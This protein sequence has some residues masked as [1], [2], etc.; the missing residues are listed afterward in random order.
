MAASGGG[1]ERFTVFNDGRLSISGTATGMVQLNVQAPASQSVDI[2]R[3]QSSV[4]ATLLAVQN[5]GKLVANVGAVVAQPG[6][7]SG[8]VLQVGGTNAG[9]TGNLQSWVNPSNTIVASINETG[10]L[11]AAGLST[12]GTVSGG[13]V[14]ST[15]AMNVASTITNTGSGIAYQPLQAGTATVTFSVQT[16][17]TQSVTFPT[18]FPAA[19]RVV[20]TQRGS[21]SGTSALKVSAD[22]VTTTG[23]TLRTADVNST[24]QTFTT[25]VDWVAVTS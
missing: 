8:T 25:N 3:V 10:Q 21:Q 15:G 16:F 1:T 20:L 11:S 14:T 9:Y 5:T 7:T 19:P 23:F 13:T 4:P 2:F 12:A 17:T 6:V 22:S 24:N 18:A